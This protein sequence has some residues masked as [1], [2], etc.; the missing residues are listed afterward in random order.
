[1]FIGG[2]TSVNVCF[3]LSADFPPP[4]SLID[5]SAQDQAFLL[6]Q[7]LIIYPTIVITL[8]RYGLAKGILRQKNTPHGR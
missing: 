4:L 8:G 2:R 5:F 1:M 6:A 7:L 3:Q